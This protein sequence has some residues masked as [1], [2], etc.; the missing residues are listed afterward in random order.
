MIANFIHLGEFC[1][2]VGNRKKRSRL[3][4]TD[5]VTVDEAHFPIDAPFYEI[6]ERILSVVP[7]L[8]LRQGHSETYATAANQ[9]LRDALASDGGAETDDDEGRRAKEPEQRQPIPSPFELRLVDPNLDRTEEPR[10]EFVF[11]SLLL[12]PAKSISPSPVNSSLSSPVN[13]SEL[14]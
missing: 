9:L 13:L 6:A 11:S 14:F 8:P 12:S 4:A 10:S 5:K 1:R 2:V 7:F 3:E